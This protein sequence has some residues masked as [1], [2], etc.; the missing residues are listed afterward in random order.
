M[1]RFGVFG[2]CQFAARRLTQ[3]RSVAPTAAAVMRISAISQRPFTTSYACL[4]KPK[5]SLG[6]NP[7]QYE[8]PTDLSRKLFS[9]FAFAFDIDGVLYQGRNRVE[10]AEKVIKMLRSNGIRYVFLTNGGCVPEDKKAET[11]QERLQIA[12]NDDVVKG[13]MILSHTP[14]SGWSDDVKNNGTVLI[15]GSHPEKARQIAF[16]Y[17]FKRVV[18]P[19]DI[20]AECKDVFPFEH[21]EGEINGRPTPLPDGKRIPLLKDPYTTNVPANALKIDHIF[22]WNDPRD[23][24]VDIQIIH[25]LLISHQG[26]IGTVS[27][28]NGNESLPNNG[29]QQ[30]GQ[31][32]L[33][34]SNLDMLWKTNYPVN[35][36]GTGAFMEA[37]K[38]VWSTTT[39]GT[40]LQ[41]SALGKPS[42]H[43]YKYAH[44]R[45]LQYYHDMACNRGQSPG[46][47][48]SKCHPLRRVYMI[49]DNPES[50]IRGASEFEAE[51]GTEWVPILVRTGVWRQTSTEKEPRYK[52]AV[53]VDDVVDAVVWALNN[54]GIKATREWVL[55]SLSHTKGYVKLP[56]LEIGDQVSLEDGVKY[57]T[58]VKPIVQALAVRES[59][60][61]GQKDTIDLSLRGLAKKLVCHRPEKIHTETLVFDGDKFPNPVDYAHALLTRRLYKWLKTESK[62][63]PRLVRSSQISSTS[64]R[65]RGAARM[66]KRKSDQSQGFIIYDTDD[67]EYPG[68]YL[69][70]DVIESIEDD[71]DLSH[72][73]ASSEQ[74]SEDEGID[75]CTRQTSTYRELRRPGLTRQSPLGDR[76]IPRTPPRNHGSRYRNIYSR[77]PGP[78]SYP[79][80]T[81]DACLTSPGSVTSPDP[82]E[83]FTPYSTAS[84]PHSAF[85]TEG[86]ETPRSSFRQSC[87][88]ERHMESPTRRRMQTDIDLLSS[89]MMRK[90]RLSVDD[91]GDH[92]EEAESEAESLR[93][94]RSMTF[95]DTEKSPVH[96]IMKLLARSVSKDRLG[97]GCV[98]CFAER[99]KPGFLKIRYV[100]CTE[101]SKSYAIERRMKQWKRDCKHDVVLKFDAFIPCAAKRIETLI[102]QTLHAQNMKASCPNKACQM[103]H[104]EWFKIE[105][106]EA[107]RVIDIWQQF[108]ELNP[109]DD[110]GGLGDHWAQYKLTQLDN[111]CLWDAKK[112]LAT[113]WVKLI[114]EAVEALMQEKQRA[115]EKE[116]G[117]R[118]AVLRKAQER[119]LK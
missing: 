72:K 18:T 48:T 60:D 7:N 3:L 93:S 65:E 25:D 111:G 40:E 10:G 64:L 62:E 52:P 83:I 78:L 116:M 63:N 79:T 107:Y 87:Y 91:L 24:S 90:M 44:D 32:G 47:D 82:S 99:S 50:D 109:Y 1:Q 43:T 28:R 77:S 113:E 81:N 70:D 115:V 21:I 8:E 4:S 33:W 71:I 29:W 94:R 105:E 114:T 31:P 22:I 117:Q 100:R 17:G 19:A 27:N 37:L 118:L 26:Y 9:E 80:P 66:S 57:P 86:C 101:F 104:K 76:E 67:G 5:G 75:E 46:H 108:S 61:N 106:V 84:T 85:S 35:R 11:L 59:N 95:D 119:I 69:S 102:H 56:P 103:K 30:D 14:M 20:L 96:N 54:E 42:N 112:W 49:G 53:I 73:G 12:K 38:G 34:I 39:N 74:D 110:K 2:Q 41:F 13:R 16:G 68:D 45:L 97:S 58:L 23:W 51:D 15:T 89:D 55:S 6:V 92:N 36:F 98:Y 88:N